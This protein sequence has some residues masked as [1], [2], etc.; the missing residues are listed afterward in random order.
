MIGQ[1]LEITINKAIKRANE[2]R[3]EYLT[4]ENV[5]LSLLEDEQVRQ[6]LGKCGA[7]L[8]YLRDN[9]ESYLHKPENF[10]I[11][12]EERVNELSEKHFVDEELRNLAAKNGVK[13]QPELSVALQRVIQR[14]AMHVQSSGKNQIMGINLLV[15]L[16][17][18]EGSYGN[19]MLQA[20]GVTR[21]K[22]LNEIAHDLDK[23][24][25]SEDVSEGEAASGEKANKGEGILESFAVNLNNLAH[26]GQI[27]RVIGREVE[28]QRL[29]E[30]LNRR[31]KNNPLI[32]GDAGVGKTALVEGFAYRISKGDVTEKFKHCQIFSLDMASM[33]AG[34]K[35]RGDFEQRLKQVFKDVANRQR[36]GQEIILFIDEIHTIMG[37]GA[38][39]SGSMDAS[40]LLKPYLSSGKIRCIGSTTH[41]EY[42]K[43]VEKDAAFKRRFQKISLDE[44][45]FEET[46]EILK[47][48]KGNY[49]NFHQIKIS[50]KTVKAAVE[51]S[52]KYI[53][54]R[55]Q[56]DKAID[57]IDEAGA[58][59]NLKIHST[60]NKKT[61]SLGVKDLE[62]VVAKIAKIPEKTMNSTES[63]VL[64]NLVR[65]LKLLIYGQDHAIELLSDT[66]LMSRSGLGD[67]TKP[68]GSF[69]FAG[70]TGVGK[71]E[72]SKQLASLLG[73]N[74]IRFDMSE[75]MEKHSVS[76]LI[77][78]PPGYVGFDQGGILTDQVN[79]SPYS[80]VLLDEIEKAHPDIYN[81]L[82]Q[83]MDHG[84]LT[85]SQGRN[86]SFKNVIL[87]MTTNAGAAEMDTG[88]IG[89][90]TKVS[91]NLHK[92]DKVIK[93]FFSPE[94]R[95]RLNAIIH[96]NRLQDEQVIQ[97]VEKFVNQ[98]SI[99]LMEK[100]I[101]L[102]VS[103]DA[104]TWFARKGYDP[105]MG[106]RPLDRLV[107]EK[108]TKPISREIL[109]GKFEKNGGF[110]DV[111]V[112]KDELKIHFKS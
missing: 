81:I 31:R 13:Y 101:E 7:D 72:L 105:K 37:A 12:S 69:L 71:T 47:G 99:K 103:K 60:E 6:V 107:R 32:V 15:A 50:N 1:R 11:L 82:L 42:R 22:I 83:I 2:L 30:V 44:P 55:K 61:K 80:V 21:L 104:F 95:N 85:D 90:H 112:E 102:N 98:L 67:E 100:S 36:N 14:A 26:D 108:L 59:L 33:I 10:S 34:A 4:L 76:K 57:L 54:D 110:I 56:P 35:F 64:R 94:F 28:I 63:V 3:H 89:I 91:E 87:I 84:A 16:F 75:Y 25:N 92:R 20:Q 62:K 39:S 97:I 77:G 19:R 65:D 8:P 86:T 51:L 45:S 9:L 5:F 88:S 73:N 29:Q 66:I 40:N 23:S 27:D 78:S 17:Q 46:V 70:P 41:E 109:F 38:T 53:H 18:E 93:N 96:F 111:T 68:I 79:K 74:F 48:M 106:A 24:I 58:R 43:F 52:T 49:E